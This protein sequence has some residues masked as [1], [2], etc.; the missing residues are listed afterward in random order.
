MEWIISTLI[1]VLTIWCGISFILGLITIWDEESFETLPLSIR[2][3]V[4]LEIILIAV[5]IFIMLVV[6]IKNVIFGK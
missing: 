3:T 1:T 6:E 5:C 4:I 2:I